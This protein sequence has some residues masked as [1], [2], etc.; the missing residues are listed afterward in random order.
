M[1]LGSRARKGTAVIGVAEQGPLGKKSRGALHPLGWPRGRGLTWRQAGLLEGKCS[2]HGFLA[3]KSQAPQCPVGRAMSP[4]SRGTVGDP[5][6]N[7]DRWRWAGAERVRVGSPSLCCPLPASAPWGPFSRAF[8]DGVSAPR[9]PGAAS[10]WTPTS[11]RQR[12][13]LQSCNAQLLRNDQDCYSCRSLPKAKWNAGWEQGRGGEGALC[14]LG[15]LR[16]WKVRA[17]VCGVTYQA[18]EPTCSGGGGEVTLQ[19]RPRLGPGGWGLGSPHPPFCPQ[20]PGRG[21]GSPSLA[22]PTW[23]T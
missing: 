17:S 18:L 6:L 20:V 3:C 13:T 10:P 14:P 9:A 15:A 8:K 4:P 2:K 12:T 16:R 11:V 23:S 7:A 5:Y 22:A 19:G 1:R 21:A